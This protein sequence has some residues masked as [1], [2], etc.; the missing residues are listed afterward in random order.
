M[1][2]ILF[3]GKR[4]DNGEWVEGY[5]CK[6]YSPMMLPHDRDAIMYKTEYD[7]RMWKPDY[8]TAEVIPE[9]IG[10]YTGL[11]DKNGKRIFEGDV[12][13]LTFKSGGQYKGEVVFHNGGFCVEISNTFVC[14]Q[15]APVYD[16]EYLG[17]IHDNPELLKGE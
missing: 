4:T 14:L 8:M 12:V 13:E 6:K 3:R 2:E 1:R 9:T 17:N 10:Q 7:V 5:L 15:K 16:F 11:T